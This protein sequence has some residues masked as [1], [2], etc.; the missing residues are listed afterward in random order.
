MSAVMEAPSPAWKAN[1]GGQWAFLAC[2]FWEALADG[3]RGGGK[4]ASLIVSYLCHV[5]K[6]YG[7]DWRGVIFRRTYPELDDLIA[8]SMTIINGCYPGAAYNKSSH[9]WTFADGEKLIFRHLENLRSYFSYHGASFPWIGFDEL[10]SW[11]TDE[12]YVAML[13]CSRPTSSRPD[14]PLMVRSTTNSYGPGHSWCRSRFIQGKQPFVPYGEPGRQRVR[15]PIQWRENEAFVEADP[16]YHARLADT[17]GNEA[18]RKAWLENSWDII[19]GGRFSDVWRESVHVLEPFDIPASWRVDRSHDW[20]S[21][22][23]FATLWYAESTGEKIDDGRSW[24]RGTIFVIGEDYGC[25]GSM[26]DVNWKPNVGIRLGPA[27]IADRT[28]M[29]ESRMREW[30]LIKRQPQPGPA[31]DPIFDVSRGRSMASVMA[32]RGVVWNKPSKGPGSRVTGWQILEDKLKASLAWPME[33]PGLF[34][35]NT[36]Q[37]LIRTLPLAQ[38]DEK[39]PEDIETLGVEDHLLDSLRLKLIS[40][41]SGN[42]IRGVSL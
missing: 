2:P 35:F 15:I 20:G 19:A 14:M 3:D 29:H 31:D 24:P 32:E 37:H 10:T 6:G 5:G 34:I 18:Q 16:G 12:A 9:E 7:A 23:P 4:S 30:G 26:Y 36:C 28:K 25:E 40:Y 21:S 27:E 33:Q 22:A 1:R 41:G 8:K 39:K 13:S 38:R 17:I 42:I 11:G